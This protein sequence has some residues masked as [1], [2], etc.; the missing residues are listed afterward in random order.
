MSTVDQN[1]KMEWQQR[2]VLSKTTNRGYFTYLED[3]SEW[4]QLLVEFF[5]Y[6]LSIFF[7]NKQKVCNDQVIRDYKALRF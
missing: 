3:Y 2:F 6:S 1:F 7:K 4:C 5:W